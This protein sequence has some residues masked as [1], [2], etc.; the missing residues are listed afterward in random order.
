M[1]SN[2]SKP[3]PQTDAQ[4]ATGLLLLFLV[5]TGMAYSYPPVTRSFP[6]L[7]GTAGIVL[8]AAECLR[9]WRRVRESPRAAGESQGDRLAMFGWVAVALGAMSVFGLVAGGSL[10]VAAFLKVRERESWFFSLLG[11]SGVVLVLHVL[12]ERLFGV[13]LYAGLL[14]A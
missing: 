10:F 9:L 4:I 5:M 7:V 14:W 8:S 2:L 13:T 12:L 3:T 1:S 11:A 6:L